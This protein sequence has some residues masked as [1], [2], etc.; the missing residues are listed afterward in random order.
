[1]AEKQIWTDLDGVK[2]SILKNWRLNPLSTV[3]RVVLGLSLGAN[4]IGLFAYDT[5]LLVPYFWSGSSWIS[6]VASGALLTFNN[7]SDL[8]D[9]V[10]A[11]ANLGLGTLATQNGTVSGINTGDQDLSPYLT[12]T[13]AALTYQPLITLGTALQYFKGDLTLGTFPT[14]VSSFN[15]DA[16]YITTEQL[17]YEKTATYFDAFSSSRTDDRWVRV[18]V[19]ESNNDNKSLYLYTR[20]IGLEFIQ[21]IA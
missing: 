10:T 1:M 7:L 16:G 15:N 13:G 11:R 4:N 6:L 12:I 20:G 3:D 18:A 19:D 8:T 21:T 9:V 17:G 14:N 2:V 5:D